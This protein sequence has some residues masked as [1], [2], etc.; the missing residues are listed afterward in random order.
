MTPADMA[1]LHRLGFSVPRPWTEG[2]FAALLAQ[3]GVFALTGDQCLALGRVVVDEAELLTITVAPDLRRKGLARLLLKR[4]L[5]H[6]SL[7]GARTCFLEVA[8]PNDAAV[9]LYIDS[10]FA[11]VGRRPGYFQSNGA[12]AMDALVM[13]RKLPSISQ[14]A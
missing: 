6:A 13:A 2:E 9:R 1:A 8:E 5:D 7:A 12:P 14:N 11:T 4:F 3:K 10:G